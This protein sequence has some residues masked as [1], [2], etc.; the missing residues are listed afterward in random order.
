MNK[1]AY[2]A[3]GQTYLTSI[4]ADEF[5]K[6]S[7]LIAQILLG[8][9]DMADMQSY[10]NMGGMIKD[11]LKHR[12]VPLINEND[13]VTNGTV[14]SYKDNDSLAVVI[15][16]AIE[17][18]MVINLSHVDGLFDKDPSRYSDAKL[19]SKVENVTKELMRQCDTDVSQH[20]SGGM[21]AKLR[22]LRLASCFGITMVIANGQKERI[23]E[24][25]INGECEGTIFLPNQKVL[26]KNRDRWLVSTK[27]STGSIKIDAG[28]AEALKKR[29]SLLA[30]G[31]TK[32][33]GTFN[34]GEVIDVLDEEGDQLAIGMVKINY[35]DLHGLLLKKEKIYNQEV[36][37]V[38]D[39]I[40]I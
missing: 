25:I 1:R 38:D 34:K 37:H 19:I 15:A 20:G 29:K 9:N 6:E 7:L 4:Y 33:Y 10:H 21:I 13:A 27:I 14:A 23:I 18:D 2:A 24:K 17:A 32:I 36:I 40:I 26:L 16:L 39:L 5:S 35:H 8:K 11:L 28:A 3:I 30:V 31:V 12:I 22:A